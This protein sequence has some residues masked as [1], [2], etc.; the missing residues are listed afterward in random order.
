[1]FIII[2]EYEIY[3]KHVLLHLYPRTHTLYNVPKKFRNTP[4]QGG[5]KGQNPP[6]PEAPGAP[7]T[8]KTAQ[9]TPKLYNIKS[10]GP[11]GATR[12]RGLRVINPVGSKS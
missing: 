8:E 9:N 11:F 3:Y 4:F 2:C 12:L 6:P 5:F 7:R 1:M 10:A